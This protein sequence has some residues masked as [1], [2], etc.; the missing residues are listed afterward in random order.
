MINRTNRETRLDG[1]WP[2]GRN[3]PIMF[4]DAVSKEDVKTWGSEDEV[5]VAFGS[6]SNTQEAEKVV[7]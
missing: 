4:V 7:R 6:K 1:F 2:C 5:H 3:V